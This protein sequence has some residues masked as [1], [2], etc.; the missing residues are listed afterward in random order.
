MLWQWEMCVTHLLT[1]STVMPMVMPRYT[2][3][4]H[5]HIY[6]TVMH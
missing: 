4:K 3:A 5:A 2:Q 6:N 1:I